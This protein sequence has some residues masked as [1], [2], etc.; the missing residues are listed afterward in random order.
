[1]TQSLAAAAATRAFAAATH[2]IADDLALVED[3]MRAQLASASEVVAL[4]GE[5]VLGSGG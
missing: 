4:L 3:A 5:H 1:M 2:R